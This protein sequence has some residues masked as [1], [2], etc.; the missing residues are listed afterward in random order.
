MTTLQ[1]TACFGN[2][3]SS[4]KSPTTG[5]VLKF[6]PVGPV[7]VSP[8]HRAVKADLLQWDRCRACPEFDDCYRLSMAKLLLEDAAGS[9]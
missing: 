4:S 6:R 8:R 7:G 2:M 3:F 1:H 9:W 5:K